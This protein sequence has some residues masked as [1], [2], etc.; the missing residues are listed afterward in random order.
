MSEGMFS[1]IVAYMIYR[2]Y[3]MYSNDMKVVAK[4][5]TTAEK[6]RAYRG[7]QTWSVR[8]KIQ[9]FNH[10]QIVDSLT[11]LSD[12]EY[13]PTSYAKSAKAFYQRE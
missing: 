13:L 4:E 5:W 2:I 9:C 7:I 8:I 11:Q 10:C 12:I 6:N 1:D 3:R